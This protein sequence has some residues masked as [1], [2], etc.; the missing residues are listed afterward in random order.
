MAR[1]I[2]SVGSVEW[3][4]CFPFLSL[5]LF[6]PLSPNGG[7][8]FSPPP[9]FPPSHAEAVTSEEKGGWLVAVFPPSLLLRPSH[10]PSNESL[11]GLAGCATLAFLPIRCLHILTNPILFP[12]FQVNPSL[13]LSL[14]RCCCCRWFELG[15]GGG[16]VRGERIVV[17]RTYLP[18]IWEKAC[19][20]TYLAY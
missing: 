2:K 12:L 10:A 11:A 16:G 1:R 7:R 18:R 9:P 6:S 15:I 17:S 5:P 3:G 20:P 8:Q 14:S 13:S 19:V 4:C